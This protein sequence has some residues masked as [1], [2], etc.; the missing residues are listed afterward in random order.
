MPPQPQVH[1]EVARSVFIYSQTS[2]YRGWSK[3]KPSD[4]HDAIELT[5]TPSLAK[6]KALR[7]SEVQHT[8]LLL[9]FA[10][11]SEKLLISQK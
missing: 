1:N 5:I 9:P 11:F 8:W 2:V 3:V 7:H 6:N 10:E 4:N